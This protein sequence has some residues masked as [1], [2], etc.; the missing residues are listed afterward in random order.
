MNASSRR[1]GSGCPCAA[2]KIKVRRKRQ[3]HGPGEP[4]LLYFQF[5]TSCH[6][7]RTAPLGAPSPSKTNKQATAARARGTCWTESG[8][9][10]ADGRRGSTCARRGTGRDPEGQRRGGSQGSVP[11]EPAAPRPHSMLPGRRLRDPDGARR[12]PRTRAGLPLGLR[13]QQDAALRPPPPHAGTS[14]TARQ[15]RRPPRRSRRRRRRP[16][17]A[18]RVPAAARIS[19]RPRPAAALRPALPPPHAVVGPLNAGARSAFLAAALPVAPAAARLEPPSGSGPLP[20]AVAA[21][22]LLGA[23]PREPLPGGSEPRPP[24]PGARGRVAGRRVLLGHRCPPSPP[25]GV[26]GADRSLR[27]YAA[28]GTPGRPPVFLPPGEGVARPAPP[29]DRVSRCRAGCCP[30][31][32]SPPRRGRRS[33]GH[34]SFLVHV[35]DPGTP[36][37]LDKR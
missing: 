32:P 15:P 21:A 16:S 13:L 3:P 28:A 35:P 22:S 17:P 9:T 14:G 30:V 5:P 36:Q 7:S 27:T 31:Q 29:R 1:G 18:R 34:R 37:T 19:R 11:G 20:D 33:W 6:Y 8:A 25:G 26:R 24:L 10:G 23:W 12:S 4:E 2:G